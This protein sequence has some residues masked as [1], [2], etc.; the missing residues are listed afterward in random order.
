MCAHGGGGRGAS[1]PLFRWF[2]RL[3]NANVLR[4]TLLVTGSHVMALETPR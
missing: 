1:D 2:Y 3:I 4:T